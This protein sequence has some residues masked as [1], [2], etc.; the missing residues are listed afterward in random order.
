MPCVD[1]DSGNARGRMA[2]LSAGALRPS[3]WSFLAQ[4]WKPRLLDNGF[5]IA[6]TDY[7][8][9]GIPGPHPYLVGDVEV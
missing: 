3:H 6:A 1:M 2:A 9:L 5:A 7:A 8:G 4:S